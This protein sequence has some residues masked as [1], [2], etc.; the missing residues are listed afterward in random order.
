MQ[1]QQRREEEEEE[2]RREVYLVWK[3]L[4]AW[5]VTHDVTGGG[6]VGGWRWLQL[7]KEKA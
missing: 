3:E 1:W 5:L 6:E 4:A 7:E 2:E